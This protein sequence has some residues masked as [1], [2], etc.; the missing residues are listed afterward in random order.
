MK[1]I[2]GRKLDI[3]KTPSGKKIPGE[4]F[5]HL[6]K[7]FE[8][9]TRFQVKQRKINELD[10]AMIINQKLSADDEQKIKE[11]LSKISK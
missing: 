7:E 8:N 11:V 5:P 4:L 10:I 3:I 2:D 6:F 9:I 1:S